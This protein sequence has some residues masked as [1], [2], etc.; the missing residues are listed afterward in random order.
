MVASERRQSD[1]KSELYHIPPSDD[2][3]KS[4]PKNIFVSYSEKTSLDFYWKQ[5]FLILK[6]RAIEHGTNI[7]LK[8]QILAKKVFQ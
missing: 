8:K 7:L 2:P 5:Q 1:Q 4:I 6:A 3:S